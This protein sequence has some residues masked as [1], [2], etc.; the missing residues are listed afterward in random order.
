MLRLLRL[1]AMNPTHTASPAPIKPAPLIGIPE[2]RVVRTAVY[3]YPPL[4]VDITEEAQLDK[5]QGPANLS[6]LPSD[7]SF[8]IPLG[9]DFSAKQLQNGVTISALEL[10][11]Y[12]RATQPLAALGPGRRIEKRYLQYP[13]GHPQEGQPMLDA[14]GA[15][16]TRFDPVDEGSFME[17]FR[18]P[19]PVEVKIVRLWT[20]AVSTL[21][22]ES[23]I[24]EPAITSIP[25]MS[26]MVGSEFGNSDF[27]RG[28]EIRAGEYTQ[29]QLLDLIPGPLQMQLLY[30]GLID[31]ST[32]FLRFAVPLCSLRQKQNTPEMVADY[33]AKNPR[34]TVAGREF[35]PEAKTNKTIG[36]YQLAMILSPVVGSHGRL[37][38]LAGQNYPNIGGGGIN[39]DAATHELQNQ[40]LSSMITGLQAQVHANFMFYDGFAPSAVHTT[41]LSRDGTWK[42]LAGTVMADN[43]SLWGG[44]YWPVSYKDRLSSSFG[45]WNYPQAVKLLRAGAA[46]TVD[47]ISKNYQSILRQPGIYGRLNA[48]PGES[49]LPSRGQAKKLTAAAKKSKP[50]KKT[51]ASIGMSVRRVTRGLNL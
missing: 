26:M 5:F 25:S 30:S 49:L 11:V 32:G 44:T 28:G 50:K 29:E 12:A 22:N 13:P 43:E 20:E 17:E 31:A 4:Q 1:I 33:L 39:Y 45:L 14:H 46:W 7:T 38:P 34:I 3:D 35:T 41:E 19:F 2:G 18:T 51:K 23:G 9:R 16:T 15:Q 10:S 21:V 40:T 24:P 37:G 36:T 8:V 42:I 48:M 6:M 47:E 27:E